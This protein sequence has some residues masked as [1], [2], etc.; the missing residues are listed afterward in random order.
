MSSLRA[1]TSFTTAQVA[2]ALGVSPQAVIKRARKYGWA[3]EERKTQGGGLQW[4]Y[5]S[6]DERAR[7]LVGLW[8]ARKLAEEEGPPQ[9]D[10]AQRAMI[11]AAWEAFKYKTN[12]ARDRAVYKQNLLFEAYCLH[13]NEGGTLKRAFEIVAERY[14]EKVS[15][16]HN[17]YYG[18]GGK[19]GVRGLDPCDW[20]A[21][22]IDNYKGRVAFAYCDPEAKAY[23]IS[24]Y[25]RREAPSFNSC[26]RRLVKAAAKKGWIIPS[27]STMR[28]MVER[29]C[30][31]HIQGYARKGK[32]KGVHPVQ[33]RRR[34]TFR[35]GE[36]V[37]G[38]GLKFDKLYVQFPD[39]EISN[40]FTGWF[41][42]DIRSGK[43]L[44][45]AWDKS[46]NENLMRRSL[47]NMLE[48]YL[49]RYV[50]LDNTRAAANKALTGQTKGRHRFSDKGTDPVG[51]LKILGMEPHFTNPDH[52]MSSPGAKPIERAFGIGGL[53]SEL[54]CWPSFQGR[55][56][57]RE[58]AIPLEEILE[59]LE[60]VVVEHNGRTGR[61]GGIC[62]GRSFDEVFAE[63]YAQTLQRKA[64]PELRALLLCSQEV[65]LVSREDASVTL[66]AGR[67]TGRHRYWG[68]CLSRYAGEHVSV[69]YRA[70]DMSAGAS[71]YSLEGAFIGKVKWLPSVAFNDKTVAQE[72]SRERA[73]LNKAAKAAAR[74]ARKMEGLERQQL[75][76]PVQAGDIPA[77]GR[78]ATVL[79]PEEIQ[80]REFPAV[81]PERQAELLKNRDRNIGAMNSARILPFVAHA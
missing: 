12:K 10:P 16:L 26:Y 58:T 37:S 42:E 5:S 36:A 4:R 50:W 13:E 48:H 33:R 53:H 80:K 79:A 40:R 73:R 61:T 41:W 38:D 17:W 52:E 19:R 14:G 44:G 49:P 24:D 21:F 81:S 46:E 72:W 67:G 29:E 35:S 55:G 7:E 64:S 1:Q 8:A 11:D 57:S 62:N 68:D 71:I 75:N 27:R 22:L 59:A 56:Y 47:Y 60:Q 39:G 20:L 77:S 28:R 76:A 54:R 18:S 69:L 43:I 15:N 23:I 31:K 34:D 2:A 9:E 51:L 78:T 30:P 6:M 74:S 65:C 45:W 25:M 70:D 63:D 3:H 32:L 66:K